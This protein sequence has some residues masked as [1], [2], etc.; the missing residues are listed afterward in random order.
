MSAHWQR[1]FQWLIGIHVP[2]AE[3]SPEVAAEVV[4][5][6]QLFN[7][8]L[9]VLGSLLLFFIEAALLIAPWGVPEALAILVLGIIPAYVL[10]KVGYVRPAIYLFLGVCSLV[11][12]ATGVISIQNGESVSTLLDC[13]AALHFGLILGALLIH[14][15]AAL[16]MM[17]VNAVLIGVMYLSGRQLSDELQTNSAIVSAFIVP[18]IDQVLVAILCWLLTSRLR[19]ANQ[20]LSTTAREL[21]HKNLTLQKNSVLVSWVLDEIPIGIAIYDGKSLKPLRYNRALTQFIGPTEQQEAFRKQRNPYLL[22]EKAE[23]EEKTRI[24]TDYLPWE[25]VLRT[26]KPFEPAGGIEIRQLDDTILSIQ[27]TARPV[28]DPETGA[29]VYIVYTAVNVTPYRNVQD[30]IA[31]HLQQLQNA[32]THLYQTERLKSQFIASMGHELRTP[33]SSIIGHARLIVRDHA[34]VTQLAGDAAAIDKAANHLLHIINDI[35]DLSKLEAQKMTL[36]RRPL[37][38]REP[39]R[40]ALES[41]RVLANNKSLTLNSSLPDQPIIAL[42]DRT[43]IKQVV[44]NLL[45][46]ALKFTRSGRVVLSLS[47]QGGDAHI[48]V[49]DTGPGIPLEQQALIFE[50][51]YQLG[52]MLTERSEGTGLGLTISRDLVALHGGQLWVQSV[53]G[54]GSTFTFSIPLASQGES[55]L[56]LR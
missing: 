6:G 32:Y 45:S 26:G 4:E 14:P 27:E 44:L 21:Q 9:L 35:L 36:N 3:L 2:P 10:C 50:R 55:A 17:A 22:E 40:E 7:T 42:A 18:I 51:F 20:R 15:S 52:D 13:M 34:H 24:I 19:Q 1:L 5:K 49:H 31:R 23:D 29:L 30:V 53:P 12:C 48:S 43:R 28:Y 8:L 41:V 56:S 33:L 38:L 37:D 39:I 16:G 54:Q 46:N 47:V 11:I 25:V